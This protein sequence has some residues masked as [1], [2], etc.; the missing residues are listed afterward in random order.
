MS[1]ADVRPPTLIGFYETQPQRS[2]HEEP[3]YLFEIMSGLSAVVEEL[4]I[5]I[6]ATGEIKKP[7]GLANA[8]RV[9]MCLLRERD[10]GE[11]VIR[12]PAPREPS[13]ARDPK[14]KTSGGGVV[15]LVRP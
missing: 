7:E 1:A 5:S 9:L 12:K 14:R 6:D 3:I 13:A 10:M 15:S 8:A 11:H 2:E 4:S